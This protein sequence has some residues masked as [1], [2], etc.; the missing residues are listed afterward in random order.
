MGRHPKTFTPGASCSAA[1]PFDANPPASVNSLNPYTIS[2]SSDRFR[3][4]GV[5]A[6]NRVKDAERKRHGDGM[7]RYAISGESA[8]TDAL[9]L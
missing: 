4:D 8:S 2:D 5:S 6:I 7:D 3:S 1:G 9:A